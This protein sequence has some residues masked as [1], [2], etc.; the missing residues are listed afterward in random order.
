MSL[1][2]IA[3]IKLY[4]MLS[5]FQTET[6]CILQEAD[7]NVAPSVSMVHRWFLLIEK[8]NSDQKVNQFQDN[9]TV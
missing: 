8:D 7:S 9:Y 6:A 5:K 1:E 2:Q 4:Q 3:K